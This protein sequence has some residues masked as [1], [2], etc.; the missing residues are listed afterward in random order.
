[1][2]VETYAHVYVETVNY[3]EPNVARNLAQ[4]ITTYIAANFAACNNLGRHVN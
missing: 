4:S 3:N 2:F 1:M